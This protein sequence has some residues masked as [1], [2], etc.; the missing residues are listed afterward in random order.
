MV[1]KSTVVQWY[2]KINSLAMHTDNPELF[3]EKDIYKFEETFFKNEERQAIMIDMYG[4]LVRRVYRDIGKSLEINES[5]Y[6]SRSVKEAMFQQAKKDGW[7]KAKSHI[8][9]G[10]YTRYVFIEVTGI[11]IIDAIKNG[12]IEK[13]KKE[14]T[15][16]DKIVTDY[17]KAEEPIELTRENLKD[18]ID[19]ALQTG[20]KKWFEELQSKMQA[21]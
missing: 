9:Y 21:I 4:V 3:L 15:K 14:D 17:S 8:D 16:M 7:E 13:L 18:L 6:V 11:K 20:D 19:L 5:T 1:S 10:Q 2:E 12:E